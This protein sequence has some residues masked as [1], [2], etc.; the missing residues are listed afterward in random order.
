MEVECLDVAGL[1]SRVLGAISPTVLQQTRFSRAGY[2]LE[3]D[4]SLTT[5]DPTIYATSG[6]LIVPIR[7]RCGG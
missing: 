6:M 4:R 5:A 7:A 3:A 2:V 1:G